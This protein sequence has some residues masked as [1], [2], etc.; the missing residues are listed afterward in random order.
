MNRLLTVILCTTAVLAASGASAQCDISGVITAV[1]SGDPMLPAYEYTLNVTFD[2]GTPYDVSH[3][4][5]L[6]DGIGGTC[7]C[8]DFVDALTIVNPSGT[9]DGHI[10]GG[11]DP[12][13]AEWDALL[14]CNGDPSIP[15][16]D[17]ILLK[18]EP[19]SPDCEPTSFGSATF[20]FYSDLHPV[21]VNEDIISLSDKFDLMYCF[22]NLSG[23]FPAMACDPVP[24]VPSTWGAAKGMFR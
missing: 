14:E 20:V 15:G 8:S 19:V 5:L 16:V 22:G 12:C 3:I 17:G 7:S 6:L 13:T 4:D 21:P 11:Y 18:F 10:L 24:N 23:V 9:S 2:T 1:P